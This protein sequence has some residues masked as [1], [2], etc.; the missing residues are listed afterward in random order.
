MKRV[1]SVFFAIFIIASGFALNPLVAYGESPIINM[2]EIPLNW[3]GEYDGVGYF[4]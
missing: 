2:N 4:L 3:Q 1:I